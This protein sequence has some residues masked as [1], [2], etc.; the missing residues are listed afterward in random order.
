MSQ[1]DSPEDSHPNMTTE[2]AFVTLDGAELYTKTWIVYPL[3]R[4]N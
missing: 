2:T 3:N 4:L 1:S